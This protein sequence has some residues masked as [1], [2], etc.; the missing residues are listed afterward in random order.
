MS[1]LDHLADIAPERVRPLKRVEYEKMV[2]DGWF[3]NE[4]IELL[5]GLIVE[6][7]PQN[8]PHAAAVQRLDQ[9]LQHALAGRAAIRVQMPLA[10]G[11][12]SLPEPDVAVVPIGDYDQR[13]PAEAFLVVEVAEASLRKDRRVKA[14]IYANA[15]IM[16]YWVVNLDGRMIEVHSDIAGAT[17]S[18]VSPAR[19]GESIRLRAF[20][21]VEI[22]VGDILK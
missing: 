10:A 20:P 8:P 11:A 13:H 4:R 22:A 6:M 15:A 16:E 12:A 14:D 21:D 5:E 9:V 17:Y 7:S 3:E 2:S 19:P 18:R 1:A